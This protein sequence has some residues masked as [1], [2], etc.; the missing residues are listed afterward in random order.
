[1][2]VTKSAVSCRFGHIYWRN[3]DG[4]LYFLCSATIFLK[5]VSGLRAMYNLVEG[6][7]YNLQSLGVPSDAYGKFAC[8]FVN[9]KNSA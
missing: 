9:Q 2:N 3:L 8:S 7:V 5:N 4:K 6:N 1:M